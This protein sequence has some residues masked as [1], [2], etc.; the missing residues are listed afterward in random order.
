VLCL[1]ESSLPS[2][3]GQDSGRSNQG[4]NAVAIGFGAGNYNQGI[5][6]IILNATGTNLNNTTANTFTVK[7][8]R[9]VN[10]IVG[11]EELYYDPKTGEIVRYVP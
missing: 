10:S 8:V 9:A 3:S 6:S 5:N 2:V 11:L 7:P 4:S 1:C